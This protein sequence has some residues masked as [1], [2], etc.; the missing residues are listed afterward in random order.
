MAR[1]KTKRIMLKVFQIYFLDSQKKTLLEGFEPFFNKNANIFLENQVMIDLF[2]QHENDNFDWFGVFS[3][4]V[5][6]KMLT[7]FCYKHIELAANRHS[8]LD[9]LGPRT[10]GYP[11]IPLRKPHNPRIQH[12]NKDYPGMW[13][14]IDLILRKL[15]I[16]DKNNGNLLNS[17][18][19][20]IYTNSF[21]CKK[22]VMRDYIDKILQPTINLIKYDNE[23][24]NLA[25]KTSDY[26][27][28]YKFPENL[29]KTSGLTSW[30]HIPF[31]LE[32]MINVYFLTYNKRT[33]F[34][35]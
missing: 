28:V 19:N 5:S 35:L 25:L 12:A 7:N 34:V 20:M 31:I 14:C 18:V 1:F 23:V 30:P 8:E 29:A 11:W 4:K 16:P 27:S 17:N 3:H 2:A 15:N 26:Q 9:I 22:D 21:L 32:R 10:E 6:K 24:R 13:E 33:A